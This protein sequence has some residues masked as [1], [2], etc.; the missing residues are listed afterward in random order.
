MKKGLLII[1]LIL[2][3][4]SSFCQQFTDLYGDYLGQTPPGDT[5]VIFAP[6]IISKGTMEHSAA[7]FSADGNEVYWASRENFS[8]N[9]KLSMWFMIRINNRWTAPKIFAPLGDSVDCY[10]PFLS[11]DGK[12]LYFG[13]DNKGSADIWYVDKQDKGWSEPQSLSPIINNS[14]NGQCQATF[15][16]NGTAYFIDYKFIEK[17]WT[18]DIVR[19]HFV[20]EKYLR[21]D[22]LPACINSI[23]SEDWTPYIAR[24][25]SYLIFSSKR[26]DPKNPCDLY[27]SFHDT[28]K[29]KWSE[30]INMG[31][32]INTWAQETFPTISPDGKYLFFTRWTNDKN[33]MDVY[34]V[35]AKIIDRLR[36]ENNVKK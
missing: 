2:I 24:D 10:D 15:T 22:T 18:C 11:A 25:D 30:P 16:Q 1:F 8:G 36:E 3:I 20:N 13:A 7:I 31:E 28:I 12:R 17:N 6:D 29:D 19:S 34:W 27:I 14:A 4:K 33:D 9:S 32:P 23:S 26:K 21:P 35:S 5:P